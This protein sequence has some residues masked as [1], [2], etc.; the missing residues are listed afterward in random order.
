MTLRCEDSVPLLG[1]Y[2]DGELDPADRAWLADHLATCGACRERKALIAAQ[3]DAIREHVVARAAGA[4]L[5]RLS[6]NVLERVARQRPS[7]P[8][9][10]WGTEMWRAHRVR[11]SAAA[12]LAL[13]ASVAAIVALR[14]PGRREAALDPFAQL[15]SIDAV[16]FVDRP[17][18]VLQSGQTA[19]IWLSKDQAHP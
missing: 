4:D 6:R 9:S 5:S 14:L 17:G 1:P 19:I 11:I 13:A 15:V 18:M 10:V 3:R 16:D 7:A 12:A 8:V 2:L